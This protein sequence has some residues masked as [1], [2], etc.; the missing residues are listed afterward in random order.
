LKSGTIDYVRQAT[1]TPKLVAAQNK[2]APMTLTNP[3]DAIACRNCSNS[4][5]KQVADNLTTCLK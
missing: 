2:K 5:W 3:R 1:T 4:T